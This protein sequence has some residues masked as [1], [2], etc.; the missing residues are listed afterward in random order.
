MCCRPAPTSNP[1]RCCSCCHPTTC[2]AGP[3]RNS[4]HGLH[5]PVAK[6][7]RIPKSDHTTARAPDPHP[8]PRPAQRAL[9]KAGLTALSTTN[10][11][12]LP[13]TQ[14]CRRS[15]GST[16]GGQKRQRAVPQEHQQA[17]QQ[18]HW[19]AELPAAQRVHLW[20]PAK[21]ERGN[22]GG[23]PVRANEG[24]EGQL[25]GLTCGGQRR[26][27]GAGRTARPSAA[28]VGGWVD[29]GWGVW[30]RRSRSAG[31]RRQGWKAAGGSRT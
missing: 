13:H 21:A 31:G 19:Q 29:G 2:P 28:G 3:T 30:V 16:C 11:P 10:V 17:V 9:S 8:A 22:S 20:G 12:L 27:R 23:E 4:R 7:T 6:T 5:W 18:G 24:R 14:N 25:R 26:Q 15:R 1:R